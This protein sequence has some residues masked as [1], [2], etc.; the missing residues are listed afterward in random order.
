[1]HLSSEEDC[2]RESREQQHFDADGGGR[3]RQIFVV[4]MMKRLPRQRN[5]PLPTAKVAADGNPGKLRFSAKCVSVLFFSCFRMR[6]PGPGLRFQN[7]KSS[8]RQLGLEHG[9]VRLA[10]EI[11]KIRASHWS[12]STD[13]YL[14]N[15]IR[16]LPIPPH[17]VLHRSC[18]KQR[19]KHILWKT[20][21]G[22]PLTSF[23]HSEAW[24]QQQ[25]QQQSQQQQPQRP[26]SRTAQG[27]PCLSLSFSPTMLH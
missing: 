23:C 16:L 22:S 13:G 19:Q 1:M 20:M 12:R 27:N 26:S 2:H 3:D 21:I 10:K 14:N 6:G 25:S 11:A 9:D 7:S 8:V 18:L 4:A 17:G 5:G 15:Y 24:Q